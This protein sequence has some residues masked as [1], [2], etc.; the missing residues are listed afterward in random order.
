M[1]I[2]TI[3]ANCKSAKRFYV[4]DGG[5]CQFLGDGAA[6]YAMYGMPTLEKETVFRL[7]DVPRE[8]ENDFIFTEESVPEGFNFTDYDAGEEIIEHS[9]PVVKSGGTLL[10]PV[11]TG[12]TNVCFIPLKY[13]KPF[14][15]DEGAVICRRSTKAGSPYIVVKVGITLVAVIV[16]IMPSESF[17]RDIVMLGNFTYGTYKNLVE[18]D[19]EGEETDNADV[20]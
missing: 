19:S 12:G 2:K 7:S 5:D 14:S 4:L 17:A 15:D 9:F 3:L 20:R 1:K 13:I 16:P 11:R 18:G 6:F 8:K 10:L